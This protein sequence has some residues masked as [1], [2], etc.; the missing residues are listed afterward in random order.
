MDMKAIGSHIRQSADSVLV[1]TRVEFLRVTYRGSAAASQDTEAAPGKPWHEVLVASW[2]QDM[3]GR[4]VS[5]RSS[6]PGAL[7]DTERFFPR[8]LEQV[9]DCVNK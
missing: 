1:V 5:K 3:L 7:K 4:C 6:P 9:G 8:Q 2:L